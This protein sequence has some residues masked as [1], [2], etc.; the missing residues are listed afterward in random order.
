M[1][2]SLT[3]EQEEQLA[4]YRDKWLSY[5]LSTAQDITPEDCD[6][7]F[8]LISELVL[9][10]GDEP[11]IGWV[12]C[13][14]PVDIKNKSGNKD[15][16]YNRGFGNH[17]AGWISFYDYME[18]VVG[19][20]LPEE[21]SH[22]RELAKKFNWQFVCPEKRMVYLSKMPTEV[23]MENGLLHNDNGPSVRYADG[24]SVYS[25]EGHRVTEQIVMSPETLTI[26]QIHAEQNAD[27]Q[28]IMINRFGWTQYLKETNAELLD[29]RKN[30]IENTI[31]V[32]YNT[33][34]FGRRLVCTCPTG[35]VFVKGLPADGADTC[36]EAQGWLSGYSRSSREKFKT[37]GRT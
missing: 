8:E 23:H 19:I 16:I 30:E 33:E 35:R 6:R 34:K 32:L 14:S 18:E 20:E 36:E 25:L 10:D 21:F 22:I 2:E 26:D 24:F 7:A 15:F 5:G 13:D 29:S 1:I 37:I 3:K 28:A 4:V 9:E 12:L 27:I 11:L 31:E 17:D